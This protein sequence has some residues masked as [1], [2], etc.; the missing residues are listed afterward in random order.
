MKPDLCCILTVWANVQMDVF[1]SASAHP[2]ALAS[3]QA[4]HLHCVSSYWETPGT[5]SPGNWVSVEEARSSTG[6]VKPS[7]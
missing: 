4:E 3:V 5:L 1:G 6:K 7:D 2:T